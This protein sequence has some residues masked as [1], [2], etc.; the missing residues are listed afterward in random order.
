MF[1][2]IDSKL[3][4]RFLQRGIHSPGYVMHFVD[5][6]GQRS[7]VRPG[8]D[9]TQLDSKY[10]MLLL[11]RQ[12]ETEMHLRDYLGETYGR[13]P[14]WGVTC[15]SVTQQD[16]G[17]LAT[18]QHADGSDEQVQCQYVVACDGA[19]SRLRQRLQWSTDDGSDYASTVLQN[20]DVELH[21]FPDKTD[22]VHYCMGPG[23]FVM[24]VQL[25]GG[26]FR[27]LMS[28]PADKAD[29]NAVPQ[30][31]FSDI[32]AQHFD[33]IRFGDT[34]WH[35]RWGSVNRLAHHYRQ[36]SV[37]LAGDAAHV[38]STA[39]GQ[40]M[41]CCMQDAY[42]LGWKL[43]FVLKGLAPDALLDTYEQER[44]PIGSQVIA[45]ASAIHELF[46]AG[47]NSDPSALL[48]L[49]E[50]DKLQSLIA[51]VSGLSYHYRS[52]DAAGKVGLQPGDRFPDYT[53][54]NDSLQAMSKLVAFMLLAVSADRLDQQALAK[55]ARNLQSY[56]D[57]FA[58]LVLEHA[59][60][61][62]VPK[63]YDQLYV[64]RPDGYVAVVTPL[65]E[66]GPLL[67]WVASNLLPQCSR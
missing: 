28:Q 50:S 60:E 29:T 45:A 64:L 59:T 4:Q 37:F 10:K 67:D 58:V 43:A 53:L 48:A 26:F 17:A 24:V 30:Q 38:H 31:V 15:S 61:I 13:V 56:K 16:K 34:R 39:G 47:R 2:R 9:F 66:P 40:G 5:G 25:P 51:Q 27:L 20:L 36:G 32:L 21:D 8:L 57:V 19:N 22:W 63:G 11:H 65:H 12:D 62:L 7:E 6:N 14:E 23:H 52:A 1:E 55:A 18:L 49:R 54:P 41:N 33:G 35:S 46:M 42:N 44:K 3:A